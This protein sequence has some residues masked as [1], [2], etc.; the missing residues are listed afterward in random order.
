MTFT[1]EYAAEYCRDIYGTPIDWVERFF[2][3]PECGDPIYEED[4]SEI[5]EW[6]TCPVCGFCFEEE[7]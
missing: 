5:N 1:W 3:C 7:R 4:W 2:L 6:H